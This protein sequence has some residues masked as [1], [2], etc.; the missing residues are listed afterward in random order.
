MNKKE[1]LLCECTGD[2]EKD[3]SGRL[4]CPLMCDDVS[5]V[6]E[7]DLDEYL[8]FKRNAVCEE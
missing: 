2:C 4:N 8:E 5:E 1:L 3:C 7:M 6:D